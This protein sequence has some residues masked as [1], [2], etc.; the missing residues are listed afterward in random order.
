[1]GKDEI[2]EHYLTTLSIRDTLDITEVELAELE[3]NPEVQRYKSLSTYYEENVCYKGKDD[4]TIL[5]AIIETSEPLPELENTFFCMGKEFTGIPTRIGTYHLIKNAAGHL[6]AT[7]VAA[8]RRMTGYSQNV[9]I[10]LD[11]A[12]DFE[13]NHNV[14]FPQTE[15]ASEEFLTTRRALYNQIMGLTLPGE[16]Q[17]LS[18]T[19]E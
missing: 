19:N 7:K 1:M 18:M 6:S 9:I 13:K 5:D 16:D 17:K 10:R 15:D 12:E 4:G 11:E 14:I 3:E 8:Y 2:K